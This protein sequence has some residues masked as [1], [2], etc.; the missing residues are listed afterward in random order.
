MQTC[1]DIVWLSAQRA[2]NDLALV[3]DQSERALTYSQLIDEINVVAAGLQER[4]I[5][6]GMRIAT[7]LPSLFDHAIAILALQRLAAIPA[8][9]NFRLKP[10]EITELIKL[11][12]IEG[13]II[14]PDD[15][16]AEACSAALGNT[17]R[18]WSVGAALGGASNFVECRGDASALGPI[19][20]PDREDIAFIF[21]TSGTTGLPKGVELAHRTTEHR[22]LWLATQTD[23][24]HGNHNKA[25]GFMPLSHAIGFYGVF[26]GI[27]G[28]GGT[29]FVQSAFNP[30]E[31][32]EMIERHEITYM[33]AVPQL[34]FAMTQ[35]PTYAPQKMKSL[36]TVLYG[37]AEIMPDFLIK[38]D[39]EWPAKI[40]H[41][42]G[43]TEIMCPFTNPDPVGEHTRLRPA[44]YVR[45][46]V[47]KIGGSVDEIA[48]PGE[49]GE[50]IVDA[51]SDLVFSSYLNRPDATEEAITDGW[52]FTGD[53][54]LVRDD[55]DYNLI[56]RTGDMVRSGGENIHPSEIEPHLMAHPDCAETA[57]IGIKDAT[58]GEMVVACVVASE[59][60]AASFNAHIKA[61]PLASYKRPKAYLFMDVLPRNAANK[62]LRRD[63]IEIANKARETGD[64]SF[65][66]V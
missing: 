45:L 31:A 19:P 42:Y 38:I 37:G 55:G 49:E 61:T 63:L 60:D 14:L 62:V 28:F 10:E 53:V 23:L 24:R 8:L 40:F 6:Q 16:M 17:D 15:A 46:R 3:D 39:K 13:A 22:I 43:T 64:N 5:R 57:I 29:F 11:G 51:S 4:G 32:I 2:P 7:V 41:I 26:L 44:Y 65:F 36:K 1:Y 58:W 59:A 18:L 66:E 48:Q 56:G 12:E 9:M 30:A 52:Y 27:L 33:F 21:Y 20:K 47:I 54:C 25:L 50:L 34:Y 35:V